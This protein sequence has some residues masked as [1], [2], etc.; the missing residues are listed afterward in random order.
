MAQINFGLGHLFWI[1]Y[2]MPHCG[3]EPSHILFHGLE[4][5]DICQVIGV[6]LDSQIFILNTQNSFFLFHQ[7]SLLL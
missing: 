6:D 4:L 3:K 1:I 5:G 2:I 7:F